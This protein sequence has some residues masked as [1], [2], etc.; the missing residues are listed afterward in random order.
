MSG[1]GPDNCAACAATEY[2]EDEYT[3]DQTRWRPV[4]TAGEVEARAE[5]NSLRAQ[6]AAVE[7]LHP[8]TEH[9]CPGEKEAWVGIY[10]DRDGA[11]H[12]TL[13]TCPTRLAAASRLSV[14]A[15]D[16]E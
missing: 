15:G 5:V 9:G 6:L 12:Y 4:Q 16:P 7:A 14:E 2:G 11:H 3:P 1:H 8:E 10:N 13:W